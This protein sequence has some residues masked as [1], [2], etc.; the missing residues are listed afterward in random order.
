MEDKINRFFKRILSED[1]NV[2]KTFKTYD[3]PYYTVF[4]TSYDQVPSMSEILK[5]SIFRKSKGD[6]L[7][8]AKEPPSTRQ[9]VYPV[10]YKVFV[11]SDNLLLWDDTEDKMYDRYGKDLIFDNRKIDEGLYQKFSY[12]Y[13]GVWD[14]VNQGLVMFTP[15]FS[16]QR[17]TILGTDQGNIEISSFGE[18]QDWLEDHVK[19]QG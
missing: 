17:F 11:N 9:R 14:V 5:T 6:A 18:L 2:D 15:A 4:F 10:V 12:K 19:I 1:V 16:G 3:E 8:L 13:D 7:D